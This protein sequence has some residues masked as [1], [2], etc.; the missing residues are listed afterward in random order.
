MTPSNLSGA[1]QR[2]G[3]TSGLCLHWRLRQEIFQKHR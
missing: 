1:Y 2:F 3:V